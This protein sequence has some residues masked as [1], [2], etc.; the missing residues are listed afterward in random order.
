MRMNEEINTL[1]K[2][3]TSYEVR[4]PI[5][6]RD[7]AQGRNNEKSNEV[8]KNLIKDIKNCLADGGKPIDFNFVYGTV[9]DNVFYPVDG[10]QRL[11]TLYLLHWFLACNCDKFDGFLTLK[12][13]SYMTRNS[14][15]DFFALLKNPNDE[16][17]YLLKESPNLRKD[18]ENRFWFQVEWGYDPTVDAAL[19]FLNDLSRDVDFRNNALQYYEKLENNA[20]NFT[21]I[22]E[23]GAGAETKAAK[24][25]IRMNARG[26]ALEPFENIKAMI[27]SIDDKLQTGLEFTTKYD[28][29]YIDILYNICSGSDS[30]LEITTTNINKKSLNY[31]KNL[32]NLNCQLKKKE[33]LGSEVKYISEIYEYSQKKLS[34]EEKD[35]FKDYFCLANTVFDYF[36]NEPNDSIIKSIF[37]TKGDFNVNDNKCIVAS[38]LYI[39]YFYNINNTVLTKEKLDKYNYILNNLNYSEWSSILYIETI[40]KFAKAVAKWDDVFDYFR[41]TEMIDLENNCKAVLEDINV[42]IKEQRIK[43]DIIKSEGLPWMYFDELETQS[44]VK[45]IQYLL[46]LSGYWGNSGDFEKLLRYIK[47]AKKYLKSIEYDLEWRKIYA[48]ATNLDC[49]HTLKSSNYINENCGTRHI[50]DDKYLFWNDEDDKNL[51]NAKMQLEE[52]KIAYENKAI[53]DS[54]ITLLP[55][56]INYDK[57]WLNYAIKYNFKA[58]IDKELIWDSNSNIVKLKYYGDYRYDMY[59]MNVVKSKKYGLMNLTV[60]AKSE[61]EFE[62]NTTHSDGTVLFTTGDRKYIM[63]LNIPISITNINDK[64]DKNKCMYYCENHLYNIYIANSPYEFTE[65]K[66]D[67]TIA[68]QKRENEYHNQL[69]VL[70]DF[71]MNNYLEIKASKKQEWKQEGRS[72]IW[73]KKVVQ[74]S[75]NDNFSSKQF[76]L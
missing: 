15:S 62:S 58:L 7:Y 30:T 38:V 25:Y 56:N 63:R 8:R 46:Y 1:I 32:Y 66:Y 45:K 16:L 53:I 76:K 39:Y 31:L 43:A 28:S 21:H 73:N 42:R 14:A 44:G 67:I 13:F 68:L 60:I 74:I 54:L 29:E 47:I 75:F 11:T 49:N 69:S 9:A 18:I 34:D 5:I 33:V 40:N 10:Q 27:D 48:I 3:L 2:L 17:R 37:D 26:K 70:N 35:Y 41:N 55:S 4:I 19:T 24:S 50:W 59:L 64:Y 65:H 71:N 23:K 36:K 61:Y 6:Q 12:N 57:C 51:L 72:S 52:I 22:I 20:I